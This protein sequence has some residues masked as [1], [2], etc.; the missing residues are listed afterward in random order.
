[1]NWLVEHIQGLATIQYTNITTKKV[2]RGLSKLDGW[3]VTTS[4]K[5]LSAQF[6]HTIGVT[7]SGFEIFTNSPKNLL[8][9]PY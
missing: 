2:Y 9:P 1:M 6:E 7:D 5:S 8:H 4:D 3:T